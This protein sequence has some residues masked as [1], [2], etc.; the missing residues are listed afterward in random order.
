MPLFDADLH[1]HSLHSIGVS[2]AMTVPRIAQ[3]AKEKGLHLL[4]TG[5]A[6]QPQWLKHLRT[7]L[8]QEGDV[9]TFDAIAFVPT[10]EIED[11]E[12]IH[13]VVI[14]PNFDAVENLRIATKPHSPNLNTEWGGR[15]RVNLGGAELAGLVRDAEGMIGPAHAFTPFKSIFRESRHSTLQTCYGDEASNI[16]FIELGL[17]ADSEIADCIPELRGLTYLTS[18]DAHSP[19]PDKLGRE[20]TRFEMESCSFEEL[21]Y[22]IRRERGRKAV[23][24]VGLNPRL[25]KYYL[26]FCS[27]CRRTLVINEG[28]GAPKFDDLNIYVNCA[29]NAEKDRILHDIHL[30]KV[31]CPAD[32]RP[33]RLGVRDRALEIGEGVSKSPDHR[34]RYLH[35]APLL[36]IIAYALEIKSSSSRAAGTLYYK[37]RT[38]FGSETSVLTNTPIES[39]RE[40]SDRVAQMIQAYRDGTACY[41][42]GGGGRYGRLIPPWEC[43]AE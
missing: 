27:K 33:L 15:P 8:K 32:G 40:V 21:R 9:Y 5:D 43:E 26:S 34:P 42:A 28:D 1:I 38:S 6:T 25:G 22:A 35:I 19:G 18:S 41:M 30:R 2:N 39:L 13:H 4:G 14:L 36:D 20:F 37:M 24:N 3:G 10:V 29:D 23:L 12:S 16:H 7:H 17:S 31:R 11:F